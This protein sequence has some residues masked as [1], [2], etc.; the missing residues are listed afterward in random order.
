MCRLSAADSS[1]TIDLTPL[2]GLSCVESLALEDG[3]FNNFP[4]LLSLRSVSLMSAALEASQKCIFTSSLHTLHLQDSSIDELHAD[5]L[6]ACVNLQDLF[7][8]NSSIY[9]VTAETS[10]FAADV[11]HSNTPSCL[12]AV[13]CLTSLSI[14]LGKFQCGVALSEQ[15]FGCLFDLTSLHALV[16]CCNCDAAVPADI[17]RLSWL[18]ALTIKGTATGIGRKSY[19]PVAFHAACARFS[20]L[21][22]FYLGHMVIQFANNVL[23]LTKIRS[24]SQVSFCQLQCHKVLTTKC[25]CLLLCICLG[26]VQQLKCTLLM[27]QFPPVCTSR[28]SGTL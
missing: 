8:Q 6:V 10:L 24:L 27:M 21:Q 26:T 18:T 28:M 9:S 22:I 7:C 17:T 19:I 16:L 3:D 4:V 12:S 2:Q 25:L 15:T 11:V 14:S 1:S 5:G 13:S 23:G 20:Q